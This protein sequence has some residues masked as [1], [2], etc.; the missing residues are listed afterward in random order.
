MIG[1]G[2]LGE[3]RERQ[4]ERERET[5]REREREYKDDEGK[6][7]RKRETPPLFSFS[8]L[9]ASLCENENEYEVVGVLKKRRERERETGETGETGEKRQSVCCLREYA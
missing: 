8:S 5:E 7:V 3:E 2:A 9:L 4:R 1:D 6:A